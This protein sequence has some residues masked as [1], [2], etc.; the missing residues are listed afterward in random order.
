MDVRPITD[1]VR[2]FNEAIAQ[3]L[4]AIAALLENDPRRDAVQ[5]AAAAVRAC[6][7]QLSAAIHESG[8]EAVHALGIPYELSGVITDWVRTGR[9]RWLEQLETRRRDA[10]T[11]LPGIGPR[12]ALE[13]RELLGIR[14]LE[15]LADA[16]RDG[17]L[18]QI[19]GF[20][21]K[22]MRLVTEALFGR[23]RESDSRQLPLLSPA[24]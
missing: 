2:M 18:Q 1:T 3:G 24:R 7:L 11:E 9:L 16:A 6:P 10:L 12:L 13:L 23:P 8:V 4:E 15:G 22:R 20:G 21:P 14:D 17:R 19:Y 5:R